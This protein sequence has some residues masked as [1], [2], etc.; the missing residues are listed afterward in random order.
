MGLLTLLR[1]LKKSEKEFRILVLG[2]DNAGKTTALKKLAD[3]DI[4]HTMPTQGFNIKSVIHEGFK[5][6]VWDIG[7]QK[8]IRPYWRNYFDQT[9]ALVFVI[10]C[11]DHRR[12]DETGVE[13]NQLLDEEKLAGVPLLIFANKQDLMNAMGPDEVTEVLGLTNIRD[14]AWHIQPCSAKTGEGLQ[15]GMEWLVKNINKS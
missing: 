5:L 2:L 10:D 8:T 15:G 4:T 3:E 13:L 11:S 14:R 9:D 6:N 12:M 1:K 7:G